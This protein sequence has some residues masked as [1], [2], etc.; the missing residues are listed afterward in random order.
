MSKKKHHEYA[1]IA[2]CRYEFHLVLRIVCVTGTLEIVFGVY[3]L[4][5]AA[6]C[7]VLSR[8]PRR[9]TSNRPRGFVPSLV[10]PSI[11]VGVGSGIGA[12]S[13]VS[14]WIVMLLESDILRSGLLIVIG[15]ERWERIRHD[16]RYLKRDAEGREVRAIQELGL[17]EKGRRREEDISKI[18]NRL[19][20]GIGI[21]D[22]QKGAH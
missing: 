15:R 9:V 1:G 17:C 14:V 10:V 5:W 21:G 4:P 3:A 6:N 20:G 8:R 18:A 2:G 12:I 13:G 7:I 19:T 11:K 16:W 22:R